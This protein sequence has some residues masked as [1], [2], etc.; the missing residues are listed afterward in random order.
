[1]E[2]VLTQ[3]HP[4]KRKIGRKSLPERWNRL[5]FWFSFFMAF[6]AIVIVQ[7]ITIYIFGLIVLFLFQYVNRPLIRMNK[8]LQWFA[9]L[10]G[11]GAIVCVFNIPS[12]A[13]PGSIE[14]A[15]A[16]LP[17]YLYWSLLIIIL[18]TH[19]RLIQLD[20]IFKAIFLGLLASIAY[21]LFLRQ[22]L[23][24]IPIFNRI[25]P[26]SFAFLLIC[27]S[28]S[29]IYYLK[30][31]KGRIWAV[32]FLIFLIFTLIY[33]GR[34]AGTVLVLLSGIA[35]LYINQINWKSF[36]FAIVV[37]P[38]LISGLYTRKMEALILQSNERIHEMI[39]KTDKIRTED[40]SYLTRVAMVNKGLAI[41]EKYPY[42]GIGLNNFSN[43]KIDFDKSFEGAA[44][45]VHKENINEK[46]AHN[47]YISLLTEGGLFLLIPFVLILISN[48][49]YFIVNIRKIPDA[50][51][52][53]FIGLIAMSV[54]LYFISDIL[55]V[56]AWFLIGL[57]S[58]VRYKRQL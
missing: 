43:I 1:M 26:N 53:I 51:L 30:Q 33:S 5:L 56:Y 4:Q 34:R 13:P 6:P 48:I 16:V 23:T 17:N 36:V 44:Y 41:F 40:R 54:H 46:S 38:M 22:F 14:R 29:A 18:I 15:F 50:H 25:T 20:N 28:P 39:Y 45:V 21:F 27:F 24:A 19:R 7:N 11:V 52:P 37:I 3:N 57:S 35:V 32:I 12:E 58:A 10:F 47:S 9:L 55:N 8:L 49:F 2:L 31:K 42:T